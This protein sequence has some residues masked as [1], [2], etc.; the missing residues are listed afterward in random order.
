MGAVNRCESYDLWSYL[1]RILEKM[2]V[3][4]G[5]PFVADSKPDIQTEISPDK[6][7]K[8]SLF[9][10]CCKHH[11]N[12]NEALGNLIHHPITLY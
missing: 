3:D 9:L 4:P 6:V 8:I 11:Q 2:D 12:A 5:L 10:P 1:R 7:L